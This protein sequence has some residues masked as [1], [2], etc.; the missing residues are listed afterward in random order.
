M[1]N[2]ITETNCEKVGV[3]PEIEVLADEGLKISKGTAKNSAEKYHTIIKDLLIV[4]CETFKV[5]LG[6]ATNLF[7]ENSIEEDT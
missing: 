5:N 6:K 1:I 4:V 3:I 2:P 7:E